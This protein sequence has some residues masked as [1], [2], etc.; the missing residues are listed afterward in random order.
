M[1]KFAIDAAKLNNLSK[2]AYAGEKSFTEEVEALK[3]VAV[4]GA[5]PKAYADA[6]K[7]AVVCAKLGLPRTKA[8]LAEAAKPEHKELRL[9]AANRLS[10][11]VKAAGIKAAN[12]SGR[13]RGARVTT[14]TPAKHAP[15]PAQTVKGPAL[16]KGKKVEAEARKAT[17]QGASVPEL[18]TVADLDQTLQGLVA[19]IRATATANPSA[20]DDVNRAALMA[21]TAAVETMNRARIDTDDDEPNF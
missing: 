15:A 17:W 10:R 3:A 8:N 18:S 11:R 21:M 5:I 9:A 19:F 20:V 12:A 16:L 4:N 6:Y 7:A 1:A 2:A 14:G 13:K